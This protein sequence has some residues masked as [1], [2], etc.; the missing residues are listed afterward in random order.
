MEKIFNYKKY[1][2]NISK[3]LRNLLHANK[4]YTGE[5]IEW[6]EK[7]NRFGA[8]DLYNR[9]DGS[10]EYVFFTKPDL[11]IFKAGGH[12]LNDDIGNNSIIYD[13]KQNNQ[14]IKVLRQL[15][16]SVSNGPFMNI[17]SNSLKN[18]VDLPGISSEVLETASTVYGSKILYRKHSY[19]SDEGHE[20]TLEF[21]DT[22]RLE[23]YALF[24]AWDEYSRMRSIGLITAND[25]YIKHQILDGHIS[26][27]KFIVSSDNTTILFYA[28]LT[29]CF[30][31][32]V[33]R[34]VF[35]ELED[36]LIYSIPFKTTWVEDMDPIIIAEFNSL[37]NN[38]QKKSLPLYNT[39]EG[40]VNG[41]WA[42]FPYIKKEDGAYKLKW[43]S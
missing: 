13:L 11:N 6:L 5:E 37:T 25:D 33:P 24:K 17:L 9:L 41:D 16:L 35:S 36:K 39:N 14:Y 7:F 1:G 22:K 43:S 34:E 4:L 18:T 12:T 30:P 27:Y 3:Q 23:L 21:E 32:S 38:R 15:Q 19:K 20:I 29:G 10:K 40:I 31:T 8:L 42:L 28:K 2:N 26:I